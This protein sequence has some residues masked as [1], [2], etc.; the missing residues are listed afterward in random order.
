M[1][2]V[3]RFSFFAAAAA[4]V[5]VDDDDGDITWIPE[6]RSKQFVEAAASNVSREGSAVR[7]LPESSHF[8]AGSAAAAHPKPEHSLVLNSVPRE[9]MINLFSRLETFARGVMT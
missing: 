5:V 3:G 2:S 8:G 6:S 7:S 1:E 4:A 9:G